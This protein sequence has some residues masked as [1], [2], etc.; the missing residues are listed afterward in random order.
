MKDMAM[1][2]G[3]QLNYTKGNP[4]LTVLL[5]LGLRMGNG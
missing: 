1:W 2:L 3:A 5:K 4:L